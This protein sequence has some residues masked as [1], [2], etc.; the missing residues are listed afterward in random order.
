M[1]DQTTS[2]P[3]DFD[4]IIVGGGLAGLTASII[5][6]QVGLSV[7]V[8]E[9][10]QYP[11][12]KVCGEYVSNEV[13]PFL[14]HLGLGLTNLGA[15]P[16]NNF[17]ISNQKGKLLRTKLPLGGFGISRYV[18]DDALYRL[19]IRSGANFTFESADFI[20]FDDDH[21]QVQTKRSS[22]QST[23]VIGAY[24]KRSMLDRQ[25]ERSFIKGKSPWLGVKAHYNVEN[26]PSNEVQLH[27]FEG[28]YGGLSM[29]ENGAVNFC[30]LTHYKSFQK[31][32]NIDVFN[33]NVVSKNPFLK[34]FLD[35]AGLNFEPPLSIAQIS[36]EKKELVHNHI[37]MCGDSAGLIHPL[38]GNGMA[39]AIHAAKIVSEGIIQF[40]NKKEYPRRQLEQDYIQQWKSNF[41]SRRYFGRKIQNLITNSSVMNRAFSIIPNSELFLSTIIKQTHGKPILV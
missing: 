28:G 27:C 24:G 11:H 34:K 37:L 39:M 38:C 15:I 29:T 12:H 26:F 2:S 36:F 21:F 16:I 10:N 9:K 32:K 30:Y 14:E 17:A 22:Y 19:A 4:I 8:M 3:D 13:R 33:K 40:F 6:S 41:G 7:L 1:H 18:L 5:L 23:I 25:L 20:E 31:T 35:E